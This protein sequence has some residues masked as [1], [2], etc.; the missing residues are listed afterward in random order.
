MHK[1]SASNLTHMIQRDGKTVKGAPFTVRSKVT[2]KDYTFKV[3]QS[4]VNDMQFMHI[5]TERKYL[6]FHYTGYYWNGRLV[7][8][9]KETKKLEEVKTPAAEAAAWLLRQLEAGQ[10]GKL[11]ASVDIFHI[12]RCLR[13]GKKLTDSQSI[14]LGFGPVCRNY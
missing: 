14:E 2:G 7:R 11:D 13:C 4:K 3:S 10:F 1:I 8:R 12:G 9:N 6:E 5:K